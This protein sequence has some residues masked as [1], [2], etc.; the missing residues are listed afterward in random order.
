MVSRIDPARKA[1]LEL[2]FVFPDPL[3]IAIMSDIQCE[4]ARIDAKRRARRRRFEVALRTYPKTHLNFTKSPVK[5][6]LA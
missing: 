3:P 2:S 1:P 5:T 4:V 6:R